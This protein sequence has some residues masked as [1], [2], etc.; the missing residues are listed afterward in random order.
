MAYREK[1]LGLEIPTPSYVAEICRR[2]RNSMNQQILESYSLWEEHGSESFLEAVW[3]CY[4][5]HAYGS[6][7][8]ELMLRVADEEREVELLVSG[9][10]A[11]SEIDRALAIYDTYSHC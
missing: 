2:D 8:I 11:Q 5:S 1:L 3:L 4:E 9:Q 6:G 7:Y 10:P